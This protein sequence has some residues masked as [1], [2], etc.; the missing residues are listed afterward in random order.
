MLELQ[1]GLPFVHAPFAALA[2]QVGLSEEGALERVRELSRDKKLRE[3]SAILESEALAYES[4]L[5][6]AEVPAVALDRVAEQVCLHPTAT[7]V[8]QRRHRLNLWFTIAVPKHMGLA[9]TLGLLSRET[10]GTVYH[11]LPRT[12]TFKIGV[13]F[14]VATGANASE[15]AVRPEL[16]VLEASPEEQAMLRALQRPLP[17]EK[18]PFAALAADAGVNEERLLSFARAHV[19]GVIRRYAGTFRHRALG[20]RANG[21]V[22]MQVPE[23]R[24]AAVG[25]A[26]ASNKEVSHCYARET[27][28]GFP[29]R[30]YAMVH[31][32]DED[33]C[34]DLAAR[35]TAG[36]DV[37]AYEVLFS[38]KEYKKT[39]LRFFLPELEAWWLQRAGGGGS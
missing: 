17:L 8:Y 3:I 5:V 12:A 29:Y 9:P 11:P 38:S 36:A 19:G 24:L 25:Q 7:H 28:P 23:E 37:E 4:A 20:V 32:P 22:A 26:I 15:A 13:V 2:E 34:R 27:A 6:A 30:L 16:A 18:A 21:M 10:G 33:A 35:L 1:R 31:G 14:D 39:R